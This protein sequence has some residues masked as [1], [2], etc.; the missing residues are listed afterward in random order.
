METPTDLKTRY[1]DAE[2][3]EFELL[4]DDKLAHAQAQLDQYTLQIKELAESDDAKAKDMD[5]ALS[6]AELERL[7]NMAGRQQKMVQHLKNAKLR[8]ANKVYGIC[9][10]TGTLIAKERLI[11]VPHT[12][13]SI[14]AKNNR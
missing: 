1:S 5:N 9:R 3:Q 7:Y 12:T 4:I 14:Q 10:E 6:S 8:I 2:L 13:L 11:A